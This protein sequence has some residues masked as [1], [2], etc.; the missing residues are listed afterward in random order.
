MPFELCNA[1]ASFQDYIN[2]ILAKKLDIFVIVYLNDIFIYIK[3]PGQSYIEA[4]RWM[5]D[6]L[7]RHGFFANLKKYLFYKDKI[8]FL[9]YIF[10]AQRVKME[11]EEI[12]AVKNWL[13]PMSVKDI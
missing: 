3:D 10:L 12:K 2:K 8:Y 13:K 9:G 6:I 7:R 11:D 4:V 5:L 1:S